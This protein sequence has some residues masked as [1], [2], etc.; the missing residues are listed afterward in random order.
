MMF[1]IV[2]GLNDSQPSGVCLEG[3]F[4]TMRPFE[5]NQIIATIA[6]WMVDLSDCPFDAIGSLTTDDAGGYR[7]GPVVTKPFYAD[8][9]SKLTLDRGPFQSAKAYYR[10]CALRELDSAKVLFAQDAPSSYQR[11]FEDTRVMVERITGLLCDLTNGCEG[12]DED[13]PEMA[14][15][16]LDIH[17]IGLK[18]IYVS[19][20]NYAHIVRTRL[21]GEDR[22]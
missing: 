16:S 5:Q 8:G 20:E 15:F 3:V 14:P 6:K 13:D 2:L 4:P 17:D 11:Q 10:S 18:N 12:L 7:T 9:R 21:V 19:P 22:T 1:C